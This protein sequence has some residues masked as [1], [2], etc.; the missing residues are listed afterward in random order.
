MFIYVNEDVHVHVYVCVHLF[1]CTDVCI[2]DV[3]LRVVAHPCNE[4]TSVMSVWYDVFGLKL[5]V[6]TVFSD[7][8]WAGENPRASPYGF[9]LSVRVRTLGDRSIIM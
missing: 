8:D 1:V 3:L 9:L 7:S 5:Q 6:L 4:A 2:F